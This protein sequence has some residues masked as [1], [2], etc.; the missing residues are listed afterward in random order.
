[1]SDGKLPW[2]W[3]WG[4]DELMNYQGFNMGK[5]SV[6]HLTLREVEEAKKH[7]V[8]A[9]KYDELREL[10]ELRLREKVREQVKTKAVEEATRDLRARLR[11]EVEQETRTKFEAEF[12]AT[13]RAKLEAKI[14]VELSSEVPHE[15]DIRAYKDYARE[16]EFDCLVQANAASEM[17]DK[18]D[19]EWTASR[20]WR[21]PLNWAFVVMAP[22]AYFFID[23]HT[24]GILWFLA[25]LTYCFTAGLSVGKTWETQTQAHK[26][27]TELRRQASEYLLLAE[28]A[29]KVRSVELATAVSRGELRDIIARL[30]NDKASQDRSFHPAT[31]TLQEARVRVRDQLA[32]E[33]DTERLIGDEE[34]ELEPMKALAK[35][36]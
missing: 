36:A 30:V 6:E 22:V 21:T 27:F 29:K 11:A 13:E 17:A 24:H 15:K 23:K 32:V 26:E 5:R 1:M 10:F 31:T 34:D 4:D 7:G 2:D 14:R 28:R 33:M 35:Q 16:V 8:T 3:P 19:R 25:L 9:E 20:R 12:N 18:E